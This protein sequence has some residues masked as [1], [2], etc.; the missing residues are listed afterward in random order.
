MKRN[1]YFLVLPNLLV[2]DMVGPSETFRIASEHFNLIYI[3]VEPRVKTSTGL[4][5]ADLAPLPEV[6]PKESWVVIPGV[7]DSS[8]DFDNP[9]AEEAAHW[10]SGLKKQVDK[11]DINI[12]C[13]CSGAILAARAGLLNSRRCTTH[14]SIL[15]RLRQKAP[16]AELIKNLLYVE[17]RGVYTCAGI[18]SGIDLALELVRKYIGVKDCLRV[19]KEMVVYLPRNGHDSQSSPWLKYRY[20]HHP[21]IHHAQDLIVS[22]PKK[23]WTLEK[24]ASEV[25]IS[26]RQLS[27]I[28]KQYLNMSVKEYHDHVKLILVEQYIGQG[29]RLESATYLSGFSSV[30]QFRR[31]KDRSNRY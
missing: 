5:L 27:R 25:H 23:R 11:G 28:F 10:I 22:E 17:D 13:I 24:I 19:A 12:L 4:W 26:S 9:Q 3:G 16:S 29:E 20:H 1:I 8:C 18:M 15:E 30:R 14:H 6:L 2:L 7:Y 31:A 21:M